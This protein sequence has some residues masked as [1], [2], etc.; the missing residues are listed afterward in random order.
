M[1]SNIEQ[2]IELAQP[3][4]FT[5]GQQPERIS[6]QIQDVITQL[7]QG[8]YYLKPD[9]Q[10]EICWNSATKNN[11]I[12]SIME[13]KLIP[14]IILY[15]LQTNQ[16]SRDN[17]YIYEVVDGQHR[18]ST[19]YSFV[20]PNSDNIVYWEHKDVNNRKVAVFYTINEDVLSYCRT[21]KINLYCELT[22]EFKIQF[23]EFCLGIVLFKTPLNYEQR[24]NIFMTL[25]NGV[26][27][28]NSDYSKNN[29]DCTIIR[30]IH[31]SKLKTL[32]EGRDGLFNK[33]CTKCPTK[34]WINWIVRC[35][36][37]YKESKKDTDKCPS[38][39]FIIGDAK[40]NHYIKIN[41][42]EINEITNEDFSEFNILFR[43]YDNFV[44]SIVTTKKLNP[45][46]IFSLFY[47]LCSQSDC[48]VNCILENENIKKIFIKQIFNYDVYNNNGK[49][50]KMWE[51]K[52]NV[53]DRKKY[54]KILYK[55]FDTLFLNKQTTYQILYVDE[56]YECES[57]IDHDFMSECS[58]FTND[59]GYD[60]N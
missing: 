46:Q 6:K 54:F 30:K 39:I 52:N 5:Q 60:T 55:L 37:L 40:I 45:T 29:F 10:R 48:T 11:L 16:R 27:V 51:S 13:N 41:H 20:N 3:D 22:E 42:S 25:Q 33:Y 7:R 15:K 31:E 14:E 49:Y 2:E 23:N 18:L 1:S 9:Y 28:R 12:K 8:Q 36:L 50:L 43:R 59:D 24:A 26:K 35:F 32:V 21:K 57:E 47:S 53:N 34:Y 4:N 38:K 58:A 19:I 56:T 17:N 44:K